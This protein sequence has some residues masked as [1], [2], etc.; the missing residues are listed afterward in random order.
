[1]LELTVKALLTVAVETQVDAQIDGG[2]FSTLEEGK[3]EVSKNVIQ[4]TP[5]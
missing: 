1:M 2:C 5:I 3:E 4:D